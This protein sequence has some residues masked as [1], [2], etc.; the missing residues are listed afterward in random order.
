V[1]MEVMRHSDMRL[2]AK[3]YTDAGLLPVADAVLSLPSLSPDKVAD[4][5]IDSQ[6]L[7][8][9][10]HTLSG[11]GMKAVSEA[12]A[13]ALHG[14]EDRQAVATAG[15]ES[16]KEENGGQNRIRTCRVSCRSGWA[17]IVR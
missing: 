7:F 8:R 15:T 1:A 16:P 9:E 17:S 14:Q 5:Q 12:W 6:S 4:S 11:A 3:T 10:G 13:E 2:T